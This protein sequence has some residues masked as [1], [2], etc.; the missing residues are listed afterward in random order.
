[1][2]R[3]INP[4]LISGAALAIVIAALVMFDERVRQSFAGLAGSPSGEFVQAGSQA[5]RF[6]STM[7]N[8]VVD[9]SVANAPLMVFVII[10]TALMLFMV[11][12]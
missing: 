3:A 6:G 9:L 10:A 4:T 11:R 8:A 2:R 12:S 5:Y 1:M 7:M